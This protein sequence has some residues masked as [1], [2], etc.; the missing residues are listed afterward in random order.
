MSGEDSS[1]ARSRSRFSTELCSFLSSLSS[2]SDSDFESLAPQ[3]ASLREALLLQVQ[4]TEED[5]V[6]GTNSAND[7][8]ALV[9]VES[10]VENNN[11]ER[12]AFVQNP[13][14]S[15]L[16][17]KKTLRSPVHPDRLGV[18]YSLQKGAVYEL[19]EAKMKEVFSRY[20][21]VVQVRMNGEK[22]IVQFR[23]EGQVEAANNKLVQVGCCVV[24]TT[25]PRSQLGREPVPYQVLVDPCHF[26]RCWERA[27]KI[28]AFFSRFGEVFA[29]DWVGY[30]KQAI[31]SFRDPGVA[32]NL[33]GREL[34]LCPRIKEVSIAT[35]KT[36]E[37]RY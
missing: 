18:V 25:L 24:H 14:G 15:Q 8:A 16:I 1:N 37:S 4:N 21:D 36:V 5:D 26:P 9:G 20:G 7:P 11:T 2:T 13:P 35:V 29:L 28:K 6:K 23:E 30:Q 34:G 3:L 32:Q 22:G 19:E 33:I 12:K 31:I 17:K 10:P 27:T